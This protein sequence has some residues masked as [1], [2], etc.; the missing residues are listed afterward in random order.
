[1]AGVKTIKIKRGNPDGTLDLT[2]NG[3]M[4]A[5]KRDFILWTINP[6]SG[7]ASIDNIVMKEG[8]T[9]IFLNHPRRNGP[10]WSGEIRW[11]VQRGQEYRYAIHWTD[12]NGTQHKPDPII[13]IKPSLFDGV[14]IIDFTSGFVTGVAVTAGVSLVSADFMDT[15]LSFLIGVVL[16][17]AAISFFISWKRRH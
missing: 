9:D 7:V 3:K 4:N 15:R 17:A 8:S 1:M 10:D 12:T 14:E 11:D 5:W 6:D 13:T 2:G 16:T